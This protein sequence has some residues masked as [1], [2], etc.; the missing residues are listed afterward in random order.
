METGD[1]GMIGNCSGSGLGGRDLNRGRA[2]GPA[3][4]LDLDP[5]RPALEP[6][7]LFWFA[8]PGSG[9]DPGKISLIFLSQFIQ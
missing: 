6:E 1:S 8:R 7:Q 3:L 5:G 2:S 9:P 4:F